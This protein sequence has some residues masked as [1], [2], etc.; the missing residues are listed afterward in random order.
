MAS[1]DLKIAEELPT[2]IARNESDWLRQNIAHTSS[3][4]HLSCSVGLTEAHGKRRP[5]GEPQ[6]YG[7]LPGEQTEKDVAQV[8]DVEESQPR[9]SRSAI[10]GMVS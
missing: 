5:M 9:I 6:L 2:K 1:V 8:H 7:A 4:L 10:V 3:S